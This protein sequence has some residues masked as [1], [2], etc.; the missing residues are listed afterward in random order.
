MNNYCRNQIPRLDIDVLARLCAVLN[1]EIGD[2][3]E[4]VPP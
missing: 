3:L 1:S 2:L 4:F